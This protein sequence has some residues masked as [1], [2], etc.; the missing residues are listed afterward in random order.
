MQFQKFISRLGNDIRL[1]AVNYFPANP[2]A[3]APL[4]IHYSRLHFTCVKSGRGICSVNGINWKL[5][6]GTVHLVMPGEM[7][8]YRADDEKPYVIYFMHFDWYGDFPQEMPRQMKIPTGERQVFFNQLH[9]LS[10]LYSQPQSPYSEYRRYGHMLLVLGELVRFS[11]SL[12]AIPVK[13]ETFIALADH[14]LNKLMR[15][16]HGPPFKFPGIDELAAI[17]GVSRRTLITLFKKQTGMT[18]KQYYLNNV[19]NYAKLLMRDKSIRTRDIAR[20]CG[21]SNLQNFLFAFKRRQSHS[22]SASG[23]IVPPPE[24][25]I[26]PEQGRASII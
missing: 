21:Y 25:A 3:T 6:A 11:T 2:G 12:Q 5:N 13:Q 18:I 24:K 7:H 10:Q 22:K 26:N 4:H 23:K 15:A 8:E 1:A 14:N 20:L 19:M 9:L 16:L 17:Y